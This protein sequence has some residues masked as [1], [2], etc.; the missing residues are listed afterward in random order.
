[1]FTTLF[2]VFLQVFAMELLTSSTECDLTPSEKEALFSE[3]SSSIQTLKDQVTVSLDFDFVD[4]VYCTAKASSAVFVYCASK[5]AI[6]IFSTPSFTLD[7]DYFQIDFMV[8]SP[9]FILG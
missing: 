8:Q 9:L 7:S 5:F 3:L 4:R 2:F 1:M 6:K